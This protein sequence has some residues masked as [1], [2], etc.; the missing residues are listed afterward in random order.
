[1]NPLD[2]FKN[3]PKEPSLWDKEKTQQDNEEYNKVNIPIEEQLGDLK[4]LFKYWDF[5]PPWEKEKSKKDD[6]V[7]PEEMH[8]DILN[9]TKTEKQ[10]LEKYHNSLPDMSDTWTEDDYFN[11]NPF[12]KNE[13]IF[14][15]SE[16][17]EWWNDFWAPWIPE[18]EN[19]E[20][21]IEKRDIKERESLLENNNTFKIAERLYNS[22]QLSN[23]SFENIMNY[24]DQNEWEIDINKVDLEDSERDLLEWLSF[25]LKWENKDQ[26]I[27]DFSADIKNI[28]E[29]KDFDKT[30]EDWKFSNEN[31]NFNILNKIWENYIKIPDKQ[32][33]LDP[34]KDI[35]T[36]IEITKNN[37]LKE[38]KNLPID[39]QTYKTAMEN[40]KSTDL[41]EQI[42]WINSLG[43]LAY[44]NE[45]K[46][47]KRTEVNIYKEQRKEEL[48]NKA[49]KITK[50][51]IEAKKTNDTKRIEKLELEKQKIIDE[52]NEIESWDIFKWWENEIINEKDPLWLLE[53]N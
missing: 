37:I 49:M 38:T 7:S 36:A 9:N 27:I 40:I 45:W 28:E 3:M 6:W 2:Q 53:Q 13:D 33:N 8:E 23:E 25:N 1:M 24:I 42:Q 18:W 5:T 21:E 51:L 15:R 16:R 47:A 50:Q 32:N 46:L 26:N 4:N 52:A 14:S 34:K 22:N 19:F 29:F 48:Q 12:N 11:K 10:V 35:S 39:S 44:S 43:I 30:M 31:W 41:S 20:E 17:E